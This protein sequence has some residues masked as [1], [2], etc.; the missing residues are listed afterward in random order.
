MK[1]INRKS[2]VVTLAHTA[3]Y[4]L[5]AE[6]QSLKHELRTLKTHCESA[7]EN[8]DEA[9][10]TIWQKFL[11]QISKL[12]ELIGQVFE[13]AWRAITAVLPKANKAVRNLE[14][15]KSVPDVID[16]EIEHIDKK[17]KSDVLEGSKFL[18]TKLKNII[19]QRLHELEKGTP[20]QPVNNHAVWKKMEEKVAEVN[21]QLDEI[22][23][24]KNNK[25]KITSKE[26]L[27]KFIAEYKSDIEQFNTYATRL[28]EDLKTIN[29]QKKKL[30]DQLKSNFDPRYWFN[31]EIDPKKELKDLLNKFIKQSQSLYAISIKLLGTDIRNISIILKSINK[32]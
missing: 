23:K 6:N 19:S 8:T 22:K 20:L 14:N 4:S 2:F 13:S 29:L 28:E 15:I 24:N 3:N 26:M 1:K 16:I 12:F 27:D 25:I 31:K 18:V 21:K 9:R 30:F 7:T 17:T 10:K 32:Q 5:I 11:A